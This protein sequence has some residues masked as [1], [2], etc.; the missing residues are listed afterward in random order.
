MTHCRLGWIVAIIVM[1]LTV[2]IVMAPTVPANAGEKM[3]HSG[4][5]FAI[6]DD[7]TTVMLAEV[8]PWQVRHGAAVITYRTITVTPRDGVCYCGPP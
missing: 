6:A 8:G 5:I 1:A 3:K 4:S 7:A 2:P